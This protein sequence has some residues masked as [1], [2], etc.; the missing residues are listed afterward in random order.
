[1]QQNGKN[2]MLANMA[3][4]ERFHKVESPNT[5]STRFLG[6]NTG[7]YTIVLI[8]RTCLWR[9]K[10]DVENVAISLSYRIKQIRNEEYIRRKL[11]QARSSL[12][13]SPTLP[14]S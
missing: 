10:N 5:F 13:T 12:F 11:K 14:A 6:W 3:V 2:K 9:K 1:M 8:W 4:V 7:G